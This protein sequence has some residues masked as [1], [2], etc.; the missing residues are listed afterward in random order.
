MKILVIALTVLIAGC[1]TEYRNPY[2]D[3]SYSYS[4]GNTT[5]STLPVK[6]KD[7]PDCDS[8]WS[9]AQIWISNNSAWKIQT[10]SD[11]IIQTYGPDNSTRAGFIATRRINPDGSGEI[12]ITAN[13]G[14]WVG[15]MPSTRESESQFRSAIQ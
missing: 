4:A 6:C 13:C 3:G 9:R 14:N 11:S 1:A 15:C 2:L 12:N 10:M 5:A 8:K 7:K